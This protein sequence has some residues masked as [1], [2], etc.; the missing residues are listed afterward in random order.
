LQAP[1]ASLLLPTHDQS[2]ERLRCPQ[3][4][5]GYPEGAILFLEQQDPRGIFVLCAGEVKLT[6][7]S[8]GGK[9]LILRI[10][11]PGEVLGL[12]AALWERSYEVTAETI[13][14]SQIAY[15]RR[16]DFRRFVAQHP[17]ASQGIGKQLSSNDHG[18]CEQ[19]RV[20]GL[21]ASA[22][23]KLARL[24]PDWSAGA[25]EA[26]LGAQITVRLTHEEIAEFIGST[27]ET[28]TPTLSDFK[29]RHL[30]TTKGSTFAIPKRAALEYFVTA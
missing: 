1:E 26:K 19:L 13:C 11:K 17:A 22:P 21:S 28:V 16:E 24:L 5:L 29:S 12:I 8:S 7:S 4:H 18:A 20:V 14:P 3:I 25:E 10:A 27:R 9:T 30:V 2:E 15:V 6:I 23:E